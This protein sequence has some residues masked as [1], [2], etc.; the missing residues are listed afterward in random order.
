MIPALITKA[1][2]VEAIRR[3][4]RDGIP[5]RR[6]GR[7][8]CLAKNGKHF[9]PKYTI[10]LAHEVATGNRLKS[11]EFSGGAESNRFLGG[12]GFDVVECNC[13]GRVHARPEMSVS[14]ASRTGAGVTVPTRHSERC[15]DCKIRVRELLERIYGTCMPNHRFRWPEKIRS[16]RGNPDRLHS[17]ESG[18][19]LG[20]ESRIRYWR[21]R[22]T[23]VPGAL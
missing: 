1:H 2:I 20:G 18:C 3:I 4:D 17:A 6:G 8:Y 15:P 23:K 13:G 22:E 5:A 10:G 21:I 7:D 9:P 12:R 16:L 11:S 14:G 19:G